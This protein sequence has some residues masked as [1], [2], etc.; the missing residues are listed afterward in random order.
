MRY[1]WRIVTIARTSPYIPTGKAV[2]LF[3]PDDRDIDQVSFASP[4]FAD[5]EV[6]EIWAVK[7]EPRPPMA[8]GCIR[9]AV[10]LEGVTPT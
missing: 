2:E 1:G 4:C 8:L 7:L 9:R 3:A 6:G 10:K 5:A